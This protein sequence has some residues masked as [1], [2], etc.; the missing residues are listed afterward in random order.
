MNLGEKCK[1]CGLCVT[2]E[3]EITYAIPGRMETT[4]VDPCLGKLP[5]VAFACCGHGD[6]K[7]AY[8]AFENGVTLRRVKMEQVEIHEGWEPGKLYSAFHKTILEI[9]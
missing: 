9:G 1:T 7:Y 8:I 4:Y 5:G 3:H 6:A 2:E